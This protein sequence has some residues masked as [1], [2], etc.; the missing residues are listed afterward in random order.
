MLDDGSLL[1]AMVRHQYQMTG[2]LWNEKNLH[3]QDKS[4]LDRRYKGHKDIAALEQ[5]RTQK[6]TVLL[7]L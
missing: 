1:I 4:P 5:S 6:Y 3:M 7:R 2:S